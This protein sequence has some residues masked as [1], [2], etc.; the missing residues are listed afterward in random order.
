MCT[1]GA[2]IPVTSRC[3]G[4]GNCPDNSDEQNCGTNIFSYL[5]LIY[6]DSQEFFILTFDFDFHIQRMYF[7]SIYVH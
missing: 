3:D 7:Q 5:E 4:V 6:T 1:N 2:C